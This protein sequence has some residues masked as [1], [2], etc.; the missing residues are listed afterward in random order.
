[1]LG[2]A[3]FDELWAESVQEC[4]GRDCPPPLWSYIRYF[5]FA[6]SYGDFLFLYK[7][8]VALT[9]LISVF[10]K[11]TTNRPL[12]TGQKDAVSYFQRLT[13]RICPPPALSPVSI[14]SWLDQ[15]VYLFFSF[16]FLVE[17]FSPSGSF[18]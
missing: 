1:M 16:F 17:F 13:L 7:L 9:P 3:Q 6:R 8:Q 10:N 18:F 15:L 2:D 11:C 12:W 14:W 4:P 5:Y